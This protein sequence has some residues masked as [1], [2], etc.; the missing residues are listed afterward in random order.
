MRLDSLTLF[1]I[2]ITITSLPQ[3]HHLVTSGGGN[4]CDIAQINVVVSQ[5]CNV[6]S[7]PNC[8]DCQAFCFEN[9]RMLTSSNILTSS[10]NPQKNVIIVTC[11]AEYRSVSTQRRGRLYHFY[12]RLQ[13]VLDVVV[14]HHPLQLLLQVFPLPPP[15][16][17]SPPPTGAPPATARRP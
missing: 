8:Y 13:P 3:L 7:Y 11:Q 16:L 4:S 2:T 1:T 12:E 10:T 5:T 17:A 14:V 6:L 15:L 9:I